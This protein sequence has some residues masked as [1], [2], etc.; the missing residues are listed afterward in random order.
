MRHVRPTPRHGVLALFALAT[1]AILSVGVLESRTL[2]TTSLYKEAEQ[3]AAGEA[4]LAARLGLVAALSSGTLSARDL[5]LAAAEYDAAQEELPLTGVVVWRPSGSAVFSRGSGRVDAQR[6]AESDIARM[7]LLR[8]RTQV[9]YASDPGVGPTVE[10]AVPLGRRGLDSVVEFHFSRAAVE[11]NLGAAKRRLYMLTVLAAIVIFVA[12]MPLLARL[13]GRVPLPTDPARKAALAALG[14][15]LARRELVLHYQPQAEVSTGRVVGVE[16]LVRWNHP[17]R[18]LLSPAAFL[19]LAESSP[20][21]LA[22]LTCQVLDRAIRDCAGWLDEGRRLPIAVNVAA[23]VLL[24]GALVRIVRDTLSRHRLD[25]RLL[26]IELTESALMERS[27]DVTAA[28][29]E[30]RDLGI[31]LSIDDFGTG[32]SSLARLRSLPL[33]ALKIDRSFIA[34]IAENERDL[35]IARHIVDLGVDLGLQVV[36][37]GVEDEATLGLLQVLGCSVVQGFFLARPLPEGELRR[38][39]ESYETSRRAQGDPSPSGAQPTRLVTGS[40]NR[41]PTSPGLSRARSDQG[42]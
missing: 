3:G 5:R 2:L 8:G 16:A 15:G 41:S 36:A 37:E 1:L 32:H 27:T 26:T 9:R 17:R 24:E 18:G 23:P 4:D 22:A 14:T 10:A 19:P 40:A 42:S 33:D 21:L 11:R 6:P 38:W 35:G 12:I 31:S 29:V 28:L 7:A 30:L 39:L 20:G 25:P 34:N 13:A